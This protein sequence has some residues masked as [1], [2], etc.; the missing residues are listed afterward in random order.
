MDTK[1]LTSVALFVGWFV[2]GIF[3]GALCRGD[4]HRFHQQLNKTYRPFRP[5][6]QF[7]FGGFHYM[8]MFLGPIGLL[9]S[10]L[11]GEG[12]PVLYWPLTEARVQKVE[13]V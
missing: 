10:V 7:E 4:S 9:V 11:A 2:C 5:D 1:L 8:I 6:A 3:G 13:T 12:P